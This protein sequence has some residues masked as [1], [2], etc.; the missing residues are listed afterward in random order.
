MLTFIDR[1]LSLYLESL[2][3]KALTM[4]LLTLPVT[5]LMVNH[6]QLHIQVIIKFYSWRD[7]V[8]CT[9]RQCSY[10]FKK[11]NPCRRLSSSALECGDV[12]KRSYDAELAAENPGTWRKITRYISR[13]PSQAIPMVQAILPATYAATPAYAA[14]FS[15]RLTY[16]YKLFEW[17]QFSQVHNEHV[18]IYPLPHP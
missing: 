16:V 13:V 11:V 2:H 3:H 17:K 8:K 10:A 6:G 15:A 5:P 9:C 12:I 1:Q 4:D 7:I 14:L 18:N